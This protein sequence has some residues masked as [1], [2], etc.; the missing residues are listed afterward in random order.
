[1]SLPN[2]LLPVPCLDAFCPV[3]KEWFDADEV[4]QLCKI[5]DLDDYAD[6]RV[7]ERRY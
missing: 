7:T 3:H 1:M 2:H 5:D 6:E 4:C